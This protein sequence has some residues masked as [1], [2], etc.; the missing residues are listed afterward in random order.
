MLVAVDQPV[1]RFAD[2]QQAAWG[3]HL[4]AVG[5]GHEAFAQGHV[6]E[7]GV[8]HQHVDRA[9]SHRGQRALDRQ[10]RQ[11]LHVGVVDAEDLQATATGR[12][13]R[14]AQLEGVDL[15]RGARECRG[16]R[17]GA[18]ADLDDPPRRQVGVALQPGHEMPLERAVP[19]VGM[20]VEIAAPLIGREV[21]RRSGEVGG[22]QSVLDRGPLLG[23]DG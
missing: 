14:V 22:T 8:Q 7:H 3:E 9:R 6:L 13:R 4:P 10:W 17:S 5:Q 16:A 21:V 19:A 1:R 18:A 11:Q 15:F 2:H 20:V 23:C 12:D